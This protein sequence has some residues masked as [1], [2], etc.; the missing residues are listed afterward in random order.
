MSDQ[1]A[2]PQA[3][4]DK[5]DA[6]FGFDVDVCALPETAKCDKY[7]TPEIDGL[8]QEWTGTVW[9]NPPY[10]REITKWMHKAYESSRKGA[11]VVALIPNRSN[12]PW[13]HEYVMR[14]D[15]IRFIRKKVSFVAPDGHA[16]ADTCPFWG[17]VIVVFRGGYRDYSEPKVK[18]YAQ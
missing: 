2:T 8:S 14:A 11:T 10:G 16:G 1:W 9:M 13:W 17:S 7:Y 12:A 6:E 4:F 5:I 3:L 15:E 18:S